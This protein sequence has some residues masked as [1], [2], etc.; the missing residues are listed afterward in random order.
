[1]ESFID[2]ADELSQPNNLQRTKAE[3]RKEHTSHW[4]WGDDIWIDESGRIHLE[5]NIVMDWPIARLENL[6][7]DGWEA[8][9]GFNIEGSTQEPCRIYREANSQYYTIELGDLDEMFDE[10]AAVLFLNG[11]RMFFNEVTRSH[12]DV[13]QYQ[14]HGSPGSHLLKQGTLTAFLTAAEASIW[15]M[16]K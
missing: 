2:R 8:R 1:M 14:F 7:N 4:L 10:D 12:E 13:G 11:A 9:I 16:Y 5:G 6:L 15:D 3:V